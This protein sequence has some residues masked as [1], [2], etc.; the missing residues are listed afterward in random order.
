[1]AFFIG[2]VFPLI[3]IAVGLGTV[4]IGIRGLIQ[5]NASADW[6][7][8]KGRVVSSSV[9]QQRSSKNNGGTST[10]YHA[11]VL[12]EFA[13]GGTTYNGNRVAY[14]DYGS[15]NP[16][17]ARRIVNQ[18]PEGETVTVHYMPDDPEQSVLEPGVQ[19]QAWILP[20]IG[21]VFLFAGCLM[22]AFLPGA[23]RKQQ[24]AAPETDDNANAR[25]A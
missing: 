21:S 10:T 24:A 7:S 4:S 8:V 20:G 3:F 22:A 5:A 16:A 14:G 23:L 2:R 1:M 12:Y 15:S 19:M 6:P 11:E 13:V 25:E 18:Y 17:H 9:D